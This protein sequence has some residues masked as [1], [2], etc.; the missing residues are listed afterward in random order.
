VGQG[1]LDEYVNP[2]LVK[3]VEE[4]VVVEFGMGCGSG[5]G[6]SFEVDERADAA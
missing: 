5:D 6:G 4:T 3:V 2:R 1:I